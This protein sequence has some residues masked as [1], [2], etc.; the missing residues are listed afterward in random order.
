MQLGP[1][2]GGLRRVD[3][4]SLTPRGG[5]RH[6]V[7]VVW[8]AGVW[9]RRVSRDEGRSPSA[10]SSG[11]FL[12]FPVR[13]IHGVMPGRRVGGV[14]ATSLRRALRARPGCPDVQ[15]LDI[16]EDVR[17]DP[18][19]LT[20]TPQTSQRCTAAAVTYRESARRVVRGHPA[21]AK[22][23]DRP[24]PKS[25]WRTGTRQSGRGRRSERRRTT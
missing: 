10:M 9:W 24:P 7:L 19:R 11:T 22:T 20:P 5:Y 21:A 1:V 14:P 6:V 13:Q 23:R 2:D 4:G 25:S 3:H 17:R 12:A 15:P 8:R 16:L 18:R